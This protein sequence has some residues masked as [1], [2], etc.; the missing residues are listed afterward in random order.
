MQSS[1]NFTDM[2][3]TR[4]PNIVIRPNLYDFPFK[5]VLNVLQKHARLALISEF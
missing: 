5:R 4:L 2:I 1:E 3:M